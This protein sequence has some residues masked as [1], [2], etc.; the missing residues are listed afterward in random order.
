[1]FVA[2]IAYT[3]SAQSRPRRRTGRDAV[4]DHDRR[5]AANLKARR[6]AQITL[7]P[8]LY[9]GK[10]IVTDRFERGFVDVRKPDHF[11]IAHDNRRAAVHD[12]PHGQF[13]LKRHADLAY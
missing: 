5:A 6:G 1:M 8:P 3:G 7:A 4:V 9:L 2:M 10:L 13:G 11:L 12:G